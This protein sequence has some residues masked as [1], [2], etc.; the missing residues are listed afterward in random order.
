MSKTRI[1]SALAAV[2]I[3]WLVAS[4][5]LVGQTVLFVDDDGPGEG[6][7]A[8]AYVDLLDA[9]NEAAALN[10]P[11]EEIWV[12]AGTYRPDR[13]TG[14]PASAFYLINNVAVYGGFSGVETSRDQRDPDV[15][16]TVLSG[17]LNGDDYAGGGN[18]DNCYHVVFGGAVDETAVLDGFT[19]SGGYANGP[20]LSERRGGGLYLVNASPTVR[21]CV[22]VDNATSAT[23]GSYGGGGVYTER[24]APHITDCTFA[25][26]FSGAGGGLLNLNGAPV[27]TGC[28]FVGND[29]F[30][31]GAI[32]TLTGGVVTLVNC[33][34]AGNSVTAY[35]GALYNADGDLSLTNC[36]VYDNEAAG[37]GGGV[38]NTGTGWLNLKNSIFWNNR[39]KTQDET[40]QVYMNGGSIL[41]NY[42]CI[43][44]WTGN[45]AGAGNLSDDP[46]FADPANV[47]D[48][49]R[50]SGG[51]PCID[52]GD[53]DAVPFA[54]TVDLGGDPRFVDDVGT[55]DTGQGLAPL[56]DMGAF[57]FQGE[58]GGGEPGEEPGGGEPGEEPG[59]GEPGE[60]PGGGGEEPVP[61]E[62][63]GM[64]QDLIDLLADMP[65]PE[66]FQGQFVERL[67]GAMDIL[68]DDNPNN[69][70][71]A[72]N[73]LEAFINAIQAQTGKKIPQ[74]VAD[75]LIA[76]LN[77][78]ITAIAN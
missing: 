43:Q 63:V 20:A 62:P 44:G 34:F 40:S 75:E 12:A 58:T 59:G 50:L 31:G 21:Q 39:D 72:T 52:A 61:E 68:A 32:K 26:N 51:S 42:S 53:N 71:A 64:M 78:I 5:I 66:S 7:W 23:G 18:S 65:I 6:D 19:I 56:V 25:N 4:P 60:E 48:G 69:D 14:D 33:V 47:P 27:L 55:P 22:F 38:Y 28:V 2:L 13:G 57:E 30:Q 67:T 49:L 1:K 16:V 37:A 11:V 36:T 46:L 77:E 3:T 74:D 54:V 17:D 45:W 24:S 76:A 8:N 70:E 73:K 9:L 15:N 41:V 35:G 10:S 29:S